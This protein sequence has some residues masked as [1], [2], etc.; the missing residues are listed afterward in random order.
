MKSL[1]TKT[2]ILDQATLRLC[3]TLFNYSECGTAHDK[4]HAQIQLG[5]L[6]NPNGEPVYLSHFPVLFLRNDN[7][8]LKIG[9]SGRLT[10]EVFLQVARRMQDAKLPIKEVSDRRVRTVR[11][12]P[13]PNAVIYSIEGATF[14]QNLEEELLCS[15]MAACS[16][17][18]QIVHNSS[19]DKCD[20]AAVEQQYQYYVVALDGQEY[21]VEFSVD[22]GQ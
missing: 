3:H 22:L 13:V 17:A 7:A 16:Y 19:Q 10:K 4:Y 20:G 18:F 11:E 15:N 12:Q 5:E 6:E 9:F 1:L 14:K 8:Q 2:P 21:R